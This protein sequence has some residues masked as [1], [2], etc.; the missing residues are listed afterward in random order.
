MSRIMHSN[1]TCLQ[2]GGMKCRFNRCSMCKS[3]AKV[4]D[5]LN[6]RHLEQANKQR[7]LDCVVMSR[8]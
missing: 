5:R 3:A 4:R 6:E 1:C 8:L 7:G 2:A